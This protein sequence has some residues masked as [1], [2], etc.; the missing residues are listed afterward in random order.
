MF[1]IKKFIVAAIISAVLLIALLYGLFKLATSQDYTRSG[2]YDGNEYRV[3]RYNRNCIAESTDG[4]FKYPIKFFH[5]CKIDNQSNSSERDRSSNSG[6]KFSLKIPIFA[7][8]PFLKKEIY[9]AGKAS[10]ILIEILAGEEYEEKSDCSFY[11]EETLS[12]VLSGKNNERTY[13]EIISLAKNEY[14]ILGAMHREIKIPSTIFV[15]TDFNDIVLYSV[16]CQAKKENFA[17]ESSVNAVLGGRYKYSVKFPFE[18]AENSFEIMSSMPR[19]L[20]SLYV[21]DASSKKRE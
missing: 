1:R 3:A 15:K 9:F 12:E 20:E 7:L 19:L 6:I 4:Y 10:D 11:E 17:C 14:K 21:E 18:Y 2:C 16:E 8:S 5:Q 13:Q